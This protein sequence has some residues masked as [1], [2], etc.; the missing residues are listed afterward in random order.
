[1][2]S[3]TGFGGGGAG[4]FGQQSAGQAPKPFGQSTGFGSGKFL[5]GWG[6]GEKETGDPDLI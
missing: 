3:G 2:F 5:Y 4:G 6:G 1:M